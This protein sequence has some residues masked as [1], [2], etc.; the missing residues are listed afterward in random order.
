MSYNPT[1]DRLASCVHRD[2]WSAGDIAVQY[3]AGFVWVVSGQRD[4]SWVVTK[5]GTQTEA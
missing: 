5:G 2:G 3:P 4:G 1:A